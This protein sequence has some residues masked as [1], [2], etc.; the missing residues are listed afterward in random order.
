MKAEVVPKGIETTDAPPRLTKSETASSP[1]APSTHQPLPRPR[2]RAHLQ[3]RL[4]RL[5]PARPP[6]HRALPSRKK[7]RTTKQRTRKNPRR[8][9]RLQ[10]AHRRA[11][12][13]AIRRTMR[14][15][16]RTGQDCGVASRRA[17][18]PITTCQ[19]TANRSPGKIP[20]QAALMIRLE[21]GCQLS[22]DGT[23]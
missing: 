1:A 16:I 6:L 9:K 13:P 15:T 22:S 7:K 17:P 11:S 19:A 5:R 20:A 18:C 10:R 8:T 4:R 14:R 3:R 23:S 12:P 21:A 2:D